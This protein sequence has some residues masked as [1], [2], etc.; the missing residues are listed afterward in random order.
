MVYASKASRVKD[1]Y[2]VYILYKKNEKLHVKENIDAVLD[3][4]F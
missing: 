1:Q 3:V 2:I 4:L